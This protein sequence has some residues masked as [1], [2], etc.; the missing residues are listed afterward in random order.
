MCKIVRMSKWAIALA[1]GGLFV[2][3]VPASKA[4]NDGHGGRRDDSRGSHYQR[5]LSHHGRS[6]HE[7]RLNRSWRSSTRRDEGRH[8]LAH[9]SREHLR[10]DQR[11]GRWARDAG[12]HRA[13]AG[14]HRL[15]SHARG[16]RH[17]WWGHR[18][19]RSTHGSH[20]AHEGRREARRS[21]YRRGEHGG[22]GYHYGH[23]W[24]RRG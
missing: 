14:H 18:S 21:D 20:P 1:V 19:A 5:R 11:D 13:G 4:E 10:R 2:I 12:N 6:H 15:A 22:R 16:G 9:S 3:A 23:R 24:Q 17:E 7:S 8:Q